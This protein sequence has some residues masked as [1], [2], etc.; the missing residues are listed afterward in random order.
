ML[1]VCIGSKASMQTQKAARP[2]QYSSLSYL[3]WSMY[4]LENTCQCAHFMNVYCWWE[5]IFCI[6]GNKSLHL[7]TTIW[8]MYFD[9]HGRLTVCTIRILLPNWNIKLLTISQLN[10]IQIFQH[11]GLDD[12]I[13]KYLFPALFRQ[14]EHDLAKYRMVYFFSEPLCPVSGVTAVLQHLACFLIQ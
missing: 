8:R 5:Y 11:Y 4:L 7:Y 12:C 6:A 2:I 14:W 13:V 3:A 9:R 1:T 10:H